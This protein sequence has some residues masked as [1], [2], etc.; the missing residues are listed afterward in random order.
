MCSAGSCMFSAGKIN[1]VS[2]FY[3]VI[4]FIAVWIKSE[5]KMSE[6]CQVDDISP[7]IPFLCFSPTLFLFLNV[8]PYRTLSGDTM[9]VLLFV[10]SL[11]S[12]VLIGIRCRRI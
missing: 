5:S 9:Q 8:G 6:K 11:V 12:P 1:S 3:T 10:M 7:L 4:N 2:F